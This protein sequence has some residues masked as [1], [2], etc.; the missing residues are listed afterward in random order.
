MLE[1]REDE[2]RLPDG[3][4]ARREYVVHPG[5]AVILPIFDDWSI[6]LE[7]Q[8]RYPVG[9]HFYELPAGKLEAGEPHL[10]TA[11]RELLEET[12]Y[13]AAEWVRLCSLHPC[14]GYSDEVVEVFVARGLTYSARHLDDEEFLETLVV[15]L[16]EALE[17]I[18]TGRI[19]DV[20]AQ[21]ALFWADR[22]RSGW[23]LGQ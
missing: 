23:P 3:N 22:L 21:M 2:V 13:E 1:V 8:F 14:I 12:G 18:R 17:W 7:R 19:T 16:D 4:Q 11:K 9:R 15:P 20:K 6:L 5:A 10:E